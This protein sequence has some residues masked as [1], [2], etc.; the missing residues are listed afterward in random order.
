MGRIAVLDHELRSLALLAPPDDQPITVRLAGAG[1]L[2]RELEALLAAAPHG[3]SA[4]DYRE[5]LLSHNV[6]GKGSATARMWAWKRLKLRYALVPPGVERNAF[7]AGMRTT[8]DAHE[9]GLLCFLMFARTDRLFREVTLDSVSPHLA[10]EGTVIDPA[11][12]EAA[13]CERAEAGNH[14]WSESAVDRAYKHLLATLKDFDV[15]RG[16]RVRRT[17]RLRPGEQTALFAARHARCEGLTD[18]RVLESRWF[19]LLGMDSNRAIDL[20]YAAN[21]RGV[22]DFRMQ[23]DVVELTLPTLDSL[24]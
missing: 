20:L 22:L 8:G 2:R 12:I 1:S 15:I 6:A 18:R 21:R 19:R 11:T 5:L 13:V 3:V 4:D 7:L 17:V 24:R 23:A 16:S 14:R 10:S 9:R